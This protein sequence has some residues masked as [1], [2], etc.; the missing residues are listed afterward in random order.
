MAERMGGAE[1]ASMFDVLSRSLDR[2]F[3]RFGDRRT[4]GQKDVDQFLA[5]LRRVLLEGDVHLD[6]V[7]SFIEDI[8]GKA[9]EQS[10]LAGVT[11]TDQLMTLVGRRLIECLGGE[12]RRITFDAAVTSVIMLVGLQGSGKTTTAAKLARAAQKHACRPLLVPLDWKRPAAVEQLRVLGEK[13][14]V[15]CAIPPAGARDVAA[16]AGEA[17][18]DA[19]RRGVGPVILDTAGR[20]HVDDALMEELRRVRDAAQPQDI[21]FVADGSVGQDA[22]VQARAFEDKIGL[23]G[24]ILTKMDGDARG[25]AALS[26]R[27]VIGRPI[28]AIGVGE[29]PDAIEDFHPDRHA[30]RILGAGDLETLFE[31]VQERVT[32]EKEERVRAMLESGRF[33]MYDFRD[34]LREVSSIGPLE[35]VLKLIPGVGRLVGRG[36]DM[37]RAE[38]E[39]KRTMAV[40]DSMTHGER[41]T[42]SLLDGSRR[43][44]IA[45]G[46]GTR[47]EDINRV[48][49]QYEQFRKVVRMAAKRGPGTVDAQS[50]LQALG[51]PGMRM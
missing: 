38:K 44:R 5:E 15:E 42:P 50:M 29:E 18:A 31:R 19:R 17:A 23:S 6:V 22:A 47:V 8:R 11:P 33:T 35:S 45:R 16:H 2:L 36:A 48:I 39:M 24:V 7:K 46:S 51:R 28:V 12:G 43:R 13:I 32:H 41:E 25:G 10:R 9:G 40:I 14:G 27:T 34:Q 3:R 21:L 26:I 20:L 37:A 49:N 30:S 1:R 4:L